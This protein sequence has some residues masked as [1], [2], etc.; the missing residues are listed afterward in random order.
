[1]ANRI[2]TATLYSTEP[3]TANGELLMN[4]APRILSDVEAGDNIYLLVENG[5]AGIIPKAAATF[6]INWNEGAVSPFEGDLPSGGNTTVPIL[7][8]KVNENILGATEISYT[9]EITV[10]C[11]NGHHPSWTEDPKIKINP[12]HPKKTN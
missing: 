10:G 7:L 4:V 1:M 8:G 5:N 6:T 12:K 9:I 2:I 11:G 3:P